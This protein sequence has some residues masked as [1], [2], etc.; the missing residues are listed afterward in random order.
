MHR[1]IYQHVVQK[2]QPEYVVSRNSLVKKGLHRR[3]MLLLILVMLLLILVM[4]LLILVMLLL[5]QN[6]TYVIA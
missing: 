4:L 6:V 1:C 3:L 5:M 2:N